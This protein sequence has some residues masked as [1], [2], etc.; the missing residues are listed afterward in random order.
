MKRIFEKVLSITLAAA[1]SLTLLP[2]AAFAAP[3]MDSSQNSANDNLLRIWYDEPATDWQ[4]Q[5][6][7]IGNGY[8]GGMVFGG[9]KK[10]KVHINEK[11]VWK[12]GPTATNNYNYG[13]TNP[14]NTEE[15]LQ[16]IKNDLNAIREKLDDK[17]EFVFGFDEASYESS[18]T[19]TKGEAMDWLNKLMG[20]LN[21]YDA[22][23]DYAD[24]FMTNNA[25]DES[26]VTNYIR[27]LDMR[28]GLATVSYDYDGVHYTR[29][30][31]NSYPDNVLVVRLTADKGG[32]I[33]FDA[34]LTDKTGGSVSNTA[35]GD[36]I[37]MKSKLRSNGLKVEAQLKVLPEGGSLTANGSSINV[38]NANSA[39]LVLACG[40]DYK[41]ELPT[42]RGEDPHEAVTGRIGAAADKGYAALKEDHVADHSALFSRMELGFNEEIPQIPTDELIKKYRNM[43]DKNG[44]EVPTESEQ[45]ALEVICYQFGRYLTIAGSREGSLPTNL[46]GVWGEGGFAWGGDYHFNINVQMNYWP[47]MASNLAE[48]QVPYNDYLNVLRE[49]GRGAAAAA[50][51]IKSE[52]GEENGWLVGCFS[53]P[54]MFASM[55]QKNNAAGWNPTGSAWALL[56]SYEYYLFSGDTEYLKNELYPSMKEVANFWNEALYWS[57]YQQRYVSGPSYSPENGPIVNGASYDQQFIWQHFENTIQAAEILGVDED[58]V[59]TWREKQSKL[60][61]VIVGD[62]GQ[63]KEWYEETTFGKAQAGD[64]EEIDIPQWRQSLG[65]GTSGQEP[66]HRHLSHLMALY[67]GNMISKDNPEYMDAAMVT[68]NERGLDATGWSKAHKLNLWAR[69]GSSDEAFQIVQSAVGG[70]NS[71]FLT[72]LFSSHGGGN[73]YKD[74]PIFQIDGNFGYTAG[75][76]EMLIQSQLGYVQFL[77]ALPEAWNTGFVKGMVARGDFEI[78]MDWADGEANTFTVTSRNGGEFSGE[79]KNIAN[80]TIT[81]AKGNPVEFTKNSDDRVTF[82]TEKDGVYTIALP[83][84]KPADKSIL[85]TVLAYAEAQYAS[86]EFENV[87][88]SVQQSFT[89]ALENA[90]TVNADSKASQEAVDSAWQTLMTEIHKLGF[91]RGDK[92]TLTQL[93]EISNSYY[94][95]IDRYTPATAEPFVAALTA[96]QAVLDDGDAM[97]GDVAPVESA[98]LDAMMNLRFKADKSVLEAVLAQAN[99][100]DLSTYSEAELAAF[101]AAKAA[102]EAVYND[103]NAEQD[104]V[105]DAVSALQAA[106]IPVTEAPNDT[107]TPTDTDITTPDAP[108]QGDTT[109]TTGGGNAKTGEA[110]PIAL[111]VAAVS[112]VGA[113]LFISKKRNR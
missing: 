22:P 97:Q 8:M 79:Y 16:K 21:G 45:R 76:N 13:N 38:A 98:L 4:T 104:A 30:Y 80:A 105:N 40:T 72:N 112:L 64:L 75:V 70:G 71:G 51:G 99:D 58:L 36:T 63:V 69:T 94:N 92:S 108:T 12:G 86:D 87:I 109:L 25:I 84:P 68:L 9:V 101:N 49:A 100:V 24:L 113:A 29:E 60:D 111:A 37:T 57:D 91:V 106:I 48:C 56:N 90:R 31:F 14:T 93:V 11:T 53:T 6:L 35:E 81:D 83:Q 66:P 85:S 96:A 32:K 88:D 54:Y 102:A 5:A 52:E 44:G 3:A 42:F 107:T 77:P 17:S 1:M 10:D 15:D 39:T 7:A 59:A 47:T 50:F 55:G 82:N 18:G 73:N 110:A 74:Y 27:D 65:A 28:T 41:M 26:A 67:P 33:N 46:Q 19:S 43:V 2:T 61:P 62:S 34:N 20:N 89:A 103:V 95:N 78:D 23:Q